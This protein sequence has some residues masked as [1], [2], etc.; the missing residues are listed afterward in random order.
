MEGFMYPNEVELQWSVLI[1]VYPFVTGLVA[2]AFILASLERIFQVLTLPSEASAPARQV[3]LHARSAATIAMQEVVFGY[4][5]NRPVLRRVSLEAQ[6]GE[7]LVL[8]GRTGAGKSSLVHLLGG[9]YTPWSGT[10]RIAGADPTVLTDAERRRALGVVLQVVQLFRGTVVDNLTLGDRSVSREAVRHAAAI[11][12]ADAF[13][14]TLPQGYNTLLGSGLQLSAGQRQLLALAR[15]WTPPV[16]PLA[17]RDV[18]ALGIEPGPEVGRLLGAVHDWWE[19]GDF[20][21]DRAACLGY[22][23]ALVPPAH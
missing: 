18:T 6:P 13:I 2:G 5:P 1:V 19:T 10:V 4:L 11:A 3:P 8:V 7:H 15:D 12:G 14:K 20:T 16:F 21:A 22:L 9:L 23:R 17:G